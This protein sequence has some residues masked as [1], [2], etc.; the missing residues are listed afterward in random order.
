ML[1][2]ILFL[3]VLCT[4]NGGGGLFYVASAAGATKG[5]TTQVF[6]TP[7]S[8]NSAVANIVVTG[9]IGDYGTATTIDKNGKVDSNGDYVKVALQKGGFEINS[10]TLNQ[11]VNALPPVEQNS[12]TCSVVF[13][14]T[15][16]V[17]LFG[18][19]GAYVGISGTL[20]VTE[21]FAGIGPRYSSG[22]KKGQCNTSS[23]AAP[24]AFFAS[25]TATGTV[26][27]S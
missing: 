27:F 22:P 6:A 3:T 8:S 25:I 9:A 7:T 24:L 21:T 11:K 26:A 23:N 12:T 1:K 10:T 19:S 4:L 18:G 15:G 20:Q 17:T 5:G 14:G 16:P 2:R 13:G